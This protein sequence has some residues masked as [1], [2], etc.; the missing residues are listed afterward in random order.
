MPRRL[1]TA[2]PTFHAPWPAPRSMRQRQGA[3]ER[4]LGTMPLPRIPD[5]Q[6]RPQDRP[7]SISEF[8]GIGAIAPESCCY[9]PSAGIRTQVLSDAWEAAET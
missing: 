2:A 1:G 8:S 7:V 6:A 5:G 9:L 3:Q 4:G